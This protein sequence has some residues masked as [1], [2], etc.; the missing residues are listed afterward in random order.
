M[1]EVVLRRVLIATMVIFSI[2]VLS[3]CAHMEK[4]PKNRLP[5]YL[6]YHKPLVEADRALDDARRA[7]KDKE[8]PAQFDAVK[9]KVDKAYEIYMACRTKEAI[10]MAQEATAEA[11]A[12]CPLKPKPVPPVAKVTDKITLSIHFDFDK[13]DIRPGDKA[14]LDKAVNF[15][16]KYPDSKIRVDGHTD[17]IGTEDY[18]HSLSHR[19]AEAVKEYLIKEAGVDP[20]RI[21][22][23]GYGKTKPIADNDTEEGRARNRRVEILIL[24]E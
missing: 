16:K 11:K 8:C 20:S 9:A 4:A 2:A 1:N 7:G 19:R 5:G 15:V 24:A 13:S 14:E 12:L 6:Y 22:A 23:A 10:Q 17:G 21:T 3:G 18:N